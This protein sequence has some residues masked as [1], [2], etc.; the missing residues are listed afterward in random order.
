M[1][2]KAELTIGGECPSCGSIMSIEEADWGC[3][4]CGY[5]NC[6]NDSDAK[7]DDDILDDTDD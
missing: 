5:P 1:G 6:D 7:E 4:C 2:R 3:G